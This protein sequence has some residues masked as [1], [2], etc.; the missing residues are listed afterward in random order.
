MIQTKG[1]ELR[2]HTLASAMLSWSTAPHR[3]LSPLHAPV[4]RAARMSE[5]EGGDAGAGIPCYR[6]SGR[7]RLPLSV[8][9]RQGGRVTKRYERPIAKRTG[10]IGAGVHVVFWFAGFVL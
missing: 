3:H 5:K 7:A 6:H 9:E 2:L 4:W 8:A 1:R 10:R